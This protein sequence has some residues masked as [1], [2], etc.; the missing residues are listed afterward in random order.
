MYTVQFITSI[1]DNLCFLQFLRHFLENRH[2]VE[3]GSV[4]LDTARCGEDFRPFERVHHCG[5]GGPGLGLETPSE[6][7]DN[8]KCLDLIPMFFHVFSSQWTR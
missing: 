5:L 2:C 4:T 8:P 3:H 1:Y 6:V 7:V